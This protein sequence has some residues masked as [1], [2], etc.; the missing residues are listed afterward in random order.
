VGKLSG[1][2]SGNL[3][4]RERRK[5]GKRIEGGSAWKNLDYQGGR[6]QYIREKG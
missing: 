1:E 5:L 3:G 2:K 6:A 4:E